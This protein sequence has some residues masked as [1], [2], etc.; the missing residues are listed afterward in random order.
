MLL[1]CTPHL[2][3]SFLTLH[4]SAKRPFMTRATLNKKL[5]LIYALLFGVLG[6]S[7]IAKL[8]PYI[9]FLNAAELKPFFTDIYDYM[10]DM[11]LIIIT[12]IAAYLA[13]VFQKRSSFVN[14][15]EREWRGI[16]QTKT[17]LYRFCEMQSPTQQDY[18]DAFCSISAT[19]DNMRIVYENVGENGKLVG[20]YPYEPLHD[21]RRALMTLNPTKNGAPPPADRKCARDAILQCF[22][23]LRE[24][25]L[26]E[27]DLE[28]PTHPLL[29]SG[30]KRLKQSGA[31]RAAYRRQ[32]KQHKTQNRRTVSGESQVDTLLARLKHEEERNAPAKIG[33]AAAGKS[34]ANSNTRS[35][36]R[37]D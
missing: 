33:K 27:L 12:V 19:L 11:A 31:A 21:M 24:N 22:A 3:R 5:S 18:L 23:A 2:I 26:E 35:P 37:H 9:P 20:L 36:R 32:N 15:L 17:A 1:S 30:G 13:N 8:A 14:S 10:K 28:Q 16:V 34:P 29:V 6:L 7:L 4:N 25:F